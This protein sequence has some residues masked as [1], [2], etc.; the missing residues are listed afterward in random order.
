MARRIFFI[1]FFF[2]TYFF[3]FSTS[4]LAASIEDLELYS[5][6]NNDVLLSARLENA[7]TEEISQAIESGAPVSFT[8]YLTVKQHRRFWSDKERISKVI[9]KIVKYDSFNKE[10]H[11]VEKI[12]ENESDFTDEKS[13]SFNQVVTSA[14]PVEENALAHN[15]TV[16]DEQQTVVMEKSEDLEKWMST[17]EKIHIGSR[18]DFS[19]NHEYYVQIK[20]KMKSI[21]LP[22]PFNYI[23]FFVSFWDFDTSLKS[24]PYFRGAPPE[25]IENPA[26]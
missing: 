1:G 9:K 16:M 4:S 18:K 19:D 6:K 12:G 15:D 14:V 8:F 24:S 21:N 13:S 5:D 11:V 2:F 17:L 10:Y 23:L 7:F 26:S 25:K 3:F 20:A 22:T